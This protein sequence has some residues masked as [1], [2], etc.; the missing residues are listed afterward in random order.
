[1][2]DWYNNQDPCIY[3]GF[4]LGYDPDADV[5]AQDFKG[6]GR[7]YLMQREP[8]RVAHGNCDFWASDEARQAAIHNPKSPQKPS[9][10]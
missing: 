9:R 7:V 6:G 10:R 1:M 8:K 3:C 2:T 4:P 5:N